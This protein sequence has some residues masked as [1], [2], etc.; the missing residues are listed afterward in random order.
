VAQAKTEPARKDM[1][2]S[3]LESFNPATGELVGTVEVTPPEA[4]EGIALE[5]AR[6]SRG[7]ALTPLM[8][9]AA[10]LRRSS[11]WVLT[12]KDDLARKLTDESGKT[13]LESLT[14][15]IM[16][17]IDTFEWLGSH[18]ARYLA[19]ERIPNAQAWMVHKRHYFLYEPLGVVG[20]I[21][22]WNYPFSIPAGE[23]GL[24]I[25]AG[26]GVLLKPSE[27][28]PLIANEIARA[29]E[30]AGLPRGVLRVLHGRGDTGAAICQAGAVKKIFFTGSTATGRKIME[31]AARQMKPVMLEL[32][33]KDA[34]V[35]LADA[36]IGRAVAGTM[37]AGFANAGQTCA[38]VERVYV[39]RRIYEEY[40]ARLIEATNTIRPGDPRDAAT[41]MGPM[42][43]EMQYEKVVE[44][45]EDARQAGARIHTGG[46]VELD[47]LDGRFIA[48]AV[49]T[50]VDHSMRIMREEVFGP[51]L[52]V[53]PFDTEE[54]AI[55]LA[56]DSPYGLGASVWTRDAKRGREVGRRLQSGMVWVNDHMYSHAI[57]QTPWGGVKDS[58]TGVTHSK[59]GLYEMTEKR[60]LSVDGGRL[61]VP[62]WY[63]YEEV[64][65]RGFSALFDGLYAPE[66]AQKAKRMWDR[67]AELKDFVARLR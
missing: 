55:A 40:V 39:D 3:V 57:A 15:E 49:L 31:A 11:Q 16:G 61:P 67:R 47:G 24:A 54:E 46:P 60:L 12:N 58:G 13:I 29:F 6:I 43:N 64:K 5:T 14:M 66:F 1:P 17:V 37:W 56:N 26:N 25:L 51:V 7:W 41:Q 20:I 10:V 18:G 23:V 2:Q 33:G 65:R 38:S 44:L 45:L 52:P 9:R 34:A 4:V 63:P 36:D 62:W 19:P 27:Y 48:P 50:D 35:V 22:P 28:T 59:Y 21:S 32:G 42:N 30:S 53:M 8:E